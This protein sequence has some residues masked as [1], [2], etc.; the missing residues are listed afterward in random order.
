MTEVIPTD[1]PKSVRKRCVIEDFGGSMCCLLIFI[2]RW[3]GG[4]FIGLSQISFFF[5]FINENVFLLKLKA[6]QAAVFNI[7]D[8]KNST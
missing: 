1:N 8:T 4:F 7:N 5:L 6:I 2:F 3:Y